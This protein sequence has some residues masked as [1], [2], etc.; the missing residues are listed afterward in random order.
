MEN[1]GTGYSLYHGFDFQMKLPL[2]QAFLLI[3]ILAPEKYTLTHFT[4]GGNVDLEA[5][6][7]TDGKEIA[8]PPAIRVLGLWLDSRLYWNAH[9]K[10]V[11]RK[12]E[13]QMYALNRIVA[14]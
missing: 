10:V 5:S 8:P 12:M 7:R 3:Y 9:I 13:T 4:Q 1:G 14:S 2:Y 11:N 6:V